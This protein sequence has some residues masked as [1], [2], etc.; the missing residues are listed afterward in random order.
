MH[1]HVYTI[2][3]AHDVSCGYDSERIEKQCAFEKAAH[4]RARALKGLR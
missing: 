4:A 1:V 2:V 3:E